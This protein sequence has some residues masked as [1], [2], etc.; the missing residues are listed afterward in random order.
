MSLPPHSTSAFVALGSNLGDARRNIN[1]ALAGL[2]RLS[3]SPI[4]V[5]SFWE[6]PPV[7]CPPGSPIF[8]NAVA[9][10]EIRAGETPSGLLAQLQ[11]L[12]REIGRQPKK[13]LNEPR[14]IDL[15]LIAFGL[16]TAAT[17][18]L[19]LPHPRAHLRRFVLEPLSEIA[20]D[21][22]FPGQNKTVA[23]MLRGLSSTESLRRLVTRQ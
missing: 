16:R 9:A 5:S 2:Q 14:V 6:S 8:I 18:E 4:R 3:A 22:T 1:V 15:D 20:P 19:V 23:E 11:S 13:T 17:P 21:F 12:E 10:L 7:D